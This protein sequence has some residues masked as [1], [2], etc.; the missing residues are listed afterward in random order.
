MIDTKSTQP[1]FSGSL[2]ANPVFLRLAST[3]MAI[4]DTRINDVFARAIDRLSDLAGAADNNEARTRLFDAVV[5]VNRERDN[6]KNHF[7]GAAGRLLREYSR[8]GPRSPFETPDATP[9]RADQM[10][11]LEDRDV[12][13]ELAIEDIVERASN[14]YRQDLHALTVRLA[15]LAERDALKPEQNP[16][17]PLNLCVAFRATIDLLDI[18]LDARL[19][20]YQLFDTLLARQLESLYDPL[21]ELLADAGIVPH[22]RWEPRLERARKRAT[23]M[24][25]AEAD[26]GQPPPEQDREQAAR[27]GYLDGWLFS[28]IQ[29][30][31]SRRR[32][33]AGDA[34]DE[35]TPGVEPS[36]LGRALHMLQRQA[37]ND[38]R[39]MNRPIEEIKSELLS[40]IQKRGLSQHQ[41]FGLKDENVLDSVGMMFD[42]VGRDSQLPDE[43]QSTLRRLQIPYLRAALDEPELLSRG[44]AP[45]KLLLNELAHTA[46]GWSQDADPRR[47]L[48]SEV[49]QVVDQLVKDYDDDPQVFNQL[50]D[51]FRKFRHREQRRAEVLAKRETEAMAGRERLTMA[52]RDVG[53]FLIAQTEDRQLPPLVGDLLR[54][55]WAHVM[56]LTL[57]KHGRESAQWRQVVATAR[58]LV[59]SVT[60]ERKPDAVRRLRCR[61][62]VLAKALAGGLKKV[63][64]S[65]ADIRNLLFSLKKLYTDLIRETGSDHVIIEASAEGLVIRGD[66][67]AQFAEDDSVEELA[68]EAAVSEVID[69][70]RTWK[71]GQ[72]VVFN[73]DHGAPLRAKL[74]WVSP[75]TGRMLFVNQRGLKAVEKS[76]HE[77]AEEL[78][79]E[80]LALLDGEEIVT[81]AMSAVAD[82]L[83]Q[84]VAKA[85]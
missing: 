69:S 63:G 52:R 66:D 41:Q 10:R 27:R 50:L 15:A 26:S 32:R 30:L 49:E 81:R 54:K 6:L 84:G 51:H 53:K 62:P 75:I 40:Q 37:A 18:E 36:A 1:S 13:E 80:K 19:A 73:R 34:R 35:N 4:L 9:L 64:Y 2:G 85:A 71:P 24:P 83:Q 22:L 33:M 3:H 46:L 60:F 59:W 28:S 39:L 5:V 45:A 7:L 57:L 68:D 21:N 79:G 20:L 72:W 12:A 29:W 16:V 78:I 11:I 38:P 8:I 43:F 76:L 25:D 74:S 70:I 67:I 77:L 55:S 42:F 61:L 58:E 48:L 23:E 56:V 44:D 17:A 14:R 65:D 31:L 47:R 82:Q